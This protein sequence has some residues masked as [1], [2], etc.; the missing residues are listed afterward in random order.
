MNPNRNNGSGD[1]WA[2]RESMARRGLPGASFNHGDVALPWLSSRPAWWVSDDGDR[3]DGRGA[4]RTGD[5]SARL[6]VDNPGAGAQLVREVL[7][8]PDGAGGVT[9][10]GDCG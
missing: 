4:A 3:C 6:R 1:H 9:E 2:S 8:E 5:N 7:G 10:D